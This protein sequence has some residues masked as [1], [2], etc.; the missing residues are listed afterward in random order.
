MRF[1]GNSDFFLG[2]EI[3]AVDFLVAKPLRNAYA[4]G[5]LQEKEFSKLYDLFQ[6]IKSKESFD[7]AYNIQKTVAS[8]GRGMVL[9]PDGFQKSTRD[10][11]E[12]T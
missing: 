11:T 10:V 4:L 3:S 6:K 7:L 12:E 2:N 9:I 5:L 8:E 1:L